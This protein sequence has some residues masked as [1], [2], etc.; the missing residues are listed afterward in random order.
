MRHGSVHARKDHPARR[1]SHHWE[2]GAILKKCPPRKNGHGVVVW[3]GLSGH[4]GPQ[5]PAAYRSFGTAGF[6]RITFVSA[7]SSPAAFADA[8][9]ADPAEAQR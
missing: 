1:Q 5:F 7:S 2:I 8:P 3:G 4:A 6:S 9:E